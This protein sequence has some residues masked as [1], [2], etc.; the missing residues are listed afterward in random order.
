[1]TT[2]IPS[3]G[4]GASGRFFMSISLQSGP[5]R[6]LAHE[7]THSLAAESVYYTRRGGD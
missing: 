6:Q 7:Q 3:D 2:V 4:A 1:M 5:P